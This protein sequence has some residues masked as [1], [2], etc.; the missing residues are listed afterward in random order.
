[1]SELTMMRIWI[2]VWAVW[3]LVIAAAISGGVA[4]KTL[5]W[6][7]YV[8]FVAWLWPLAFIIPVWARLLWKLFRQ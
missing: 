3:T 7:V 8:W 4:R 5:R 1:M 6:M 2:V